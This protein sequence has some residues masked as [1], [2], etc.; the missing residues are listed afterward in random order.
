MG[1]VDCVE[2]R[3]S[4][5]ARLDG[6][7]ELGPA[8]HTD[9]HLDRCAAC[10]VWWRR[11][12]GLN[13][14]LRVRPATP[15]PDLTAVILEN[16]PPPAPAQGWWARG[17][18]TAVASAQVAL[19]LG[20]VFGMLTIHHGGEPVA[21]HLFNE[22]T[23]WNLALGI[24][25]LWAAFRPRVTSGLIPALTAFVVVLFAYST[26][27]L[28]TGAAPVQRVAGHTLL[29]AGLI[30]LVVVNRQTGTPS[31]G[32]AAGTGSASTSAADPP[33]PGPADDSTGRPP[34]RPASRHDAA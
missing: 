3:E 24:G 5:S 23:A 30:L 8:E 32:S 12:S 16:A 4:L 34:L 10:Q 7:D 26:H 11:A 17:A 27:D 9:G 28:I 6:E 14:T 2:C 15:V 33:E 19:A 22:S 18:L 21:T 20:Q 25:M 1:L 31:P 13:R 29:V